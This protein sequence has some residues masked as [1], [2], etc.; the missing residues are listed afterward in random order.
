MGGVEG[1]TKEGKGINRDR[2]LQVFELL[3]REY[4]MEEGKRNTSVIKIV[5]RNIYGRDTY[6]PANQL[7]QTL[8]GLLNQK[9]LTPENLRHLTRGGFEVITEVENSEKWKEGI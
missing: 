1:K 7:A 4:T 3:R 2:K 9:T 5:S 8:A 6:Y